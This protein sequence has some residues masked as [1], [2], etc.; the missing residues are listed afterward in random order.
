MVSV[1]RSCFIAVFVVGC[2]TVF[3]HA[4]ITEDTMCDFYNGLSDILDRNINSPDHAVS[5][6]KAY[7]DRHQALLDQITQAAQKGQQM[8][9]SMNAMN[10]GQSMNPMNISQG[11]MAQAME[12]VSKSKMTGVMT[13]YMQSMM[14][15]AM[16]NQDHADAIAELMSRMAP[17]SQ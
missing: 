13:R 16:Q 17:G 15:F 9:Q 6:T 2:L 7:L 4:Q 8:A 11:Q 10:M 5:Q 1:I 12:T 3:A 14:R